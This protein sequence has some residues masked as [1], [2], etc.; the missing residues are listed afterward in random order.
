[1]TA[2]SPHAT[3]TP[4]RAA[5][6]QTRQIQQMLTRDIPAATIAAACGC[7]IARVQHVAGIHHQQLPHPNPPGPQPIP[8]LLAAG[9]AHPNPD[10]NRLT[11]R[12]VHDLATLRDQLQDDQT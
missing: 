2:G 8:D 6:A 7:T 3:R 10:I 11:H 5:T 12:I 1:M 9:H 4:T